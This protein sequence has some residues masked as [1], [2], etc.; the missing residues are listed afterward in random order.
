[1]KY[2]LLTYDRRRHKILAVAAFA[3]EDR[4]RAL[5]ERGTLVRQ[6]RA[7][8]D[9]EIVLLGANSYEDLE[10]THSRYFKTVNQLAK[11][12]NTH[13]SDPALTN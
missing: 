12:K 11:R 9:L 13:R 3:L 5:A 10:K 4:D 7:N 8:L 6:H 1:V 2:F